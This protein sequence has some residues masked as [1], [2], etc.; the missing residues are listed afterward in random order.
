M[1]RIIILHPLLFAAYPV[2]SLF[3]RNIDEIE[4]AVLTR[5]LIVSVVVT[6]ILWLLF[7][8]V[9]KDW[10]KAGIITSMLVFWFFSYGHF[11]TFL[12]NSN[13]DL[14][15]AIRR[16]RYLVPLTLALLAVLI[17]WVIRTKRSMRNVTQFLNL[18]AVLAIAFPLYSLTTYAIHNGGQ[19]LSSQSETDEL[20]LP[21]AEPAPDIYYII[22]DAYAREDTLKEVYDYDN[23]TFVNALEDRG[24]YV[25]D[26]SRSNYSYTS[27]SIASSLNMDYVE[28]L[29]V[30]LDSDDK[31]QSP[32][33]ELIK[34][35]RVR[36]ALE[37]IGYETVAFS[38][39]YPGTEIEDADIYITGGTLDQ[40]L[41]LKA[42]SSFE[43]M[44]IDYS[45]AK[46]IIDGA[47]ILPLFFPNLQYPYQYHREL[48]LNVFTQLSRIP[49]MEGSK[50]IFAHIIAPH[51]PF[52][53]KSDGSIVDRLP[54]FTFGFT[55]GGG[56]S[57]SDSEYIQGY[58]DQLH[59][60]NT[61]VLETIDDIL[62]LSVTPP[63]II[64]QGDHGP[65]PV[66]TNMPYARQRTATFKAFYLPGNDHTLLYPSITPV[67][68]FRVVFNTMFGG[69]YQL[70]PDLV[71]YSVHPKIFDFTDVTETYD[72]N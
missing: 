16:H 70:L 43:G 22:L 69:T 46:I 37:A 42:L 62:E 9:I 8:L 31:N 3:A 59:F 60:I 54:G 38:T 11:Y 58:R 24:F 18:L 65:V 71:F 32:L 15:Q 44:L 68:D 40:I 27:L 25:V 13:I 35:S 36:Q 7:K 29:I 23:S 45:A 56:E 72:N 1:K 41:D 48:I 26:Q 20:I 51:S 57:Y 33:W 50:F 49:E 10:Q 14:L 6:C 61:Q 67:N 4:F 66:G 39:G 64:I 53:F 2:L 5:P 52:V 28:N 12:R 47:T 21:V 30:G 34:H 17:Y 55:F 19:I 63:V